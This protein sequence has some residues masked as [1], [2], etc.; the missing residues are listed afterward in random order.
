MIAI[1]FL[2]GFISDE[3]GSWGEAA[4]FITESAPVFFFI[5]FGMTVMRASGRT[6][7][8]R[9]IFE[10]GIIALFHQVYRDAVLTFQCEFFLF[11]C[12]AF[13]ISTLFHKLFANRWIR[14]ILA[15]AIIIANLLIGHENM[16]VCGSH[17]FGIMPWIFFVIV[18]MMIGTKPIEQ[19]EHIPIVAYALALFVIGLAINLYGLRYGM[20]YLH[21]TISKWEPTTPSYML[22]WTS[23]ALCAYVL[24]NRIRYNPKSSIA[25]IITISSK[26]LLTG[27][28][29]HYITSDFAAYVMNSGGYGLD[30]HMPWHLAAISLITIYAGVY[31]VLLS[32]SDIKQIVLGNIKSEK[33]INKSG[34]CVLVILAI[35]SLA[36]LYTNPDSV[37]PV[38][39]AKVGMLI[40]AFLFL[41]PDY[42]ELSGP[43][44]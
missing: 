31:V 43:R 35:A 44:T 11:L 18:G 9:S 36:L 27:V 24:F 33:L 3:P 38:N 22:I 19:K 17:P 6:G 13:L 2:R 25:K 41:T 39:I 34:W 15:A 40:A 8:L 5:A 29:V 20:H 7:R 16:G 42:D 10:L 26:M 30:N 1:H 21:A 12:L 14:L 28:V 4:R 32:L 37:A 23:I